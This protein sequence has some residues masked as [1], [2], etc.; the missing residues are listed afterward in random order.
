MVYEY[1]ATLSRRDNIN[2][3]VQSFTLR[4]YYTDVFKEFIVQHAQ[5]FLLYLLRS[6]LK[7]IQLDLKI[8]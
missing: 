2:A 1:M 4:C 6:L 8:I 3:N 7:C 5:R